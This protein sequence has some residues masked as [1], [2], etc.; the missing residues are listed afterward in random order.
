M[1]RRKFVSYR[2][3]GKTFVKDLSCPSISWIS[4][5]ACWSEI[6]TLLYKN[7]NDVNSLQELAD[8]KFS[9][10]KVYSEAQ[11]VDFDG[12]KILFVDRW[13]NNQ[14]Y[15]HSMGTIDETTAQICMGHLE[16]EWL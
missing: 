10:I 2:I 1:D 13:I 8:G 3:G 14:N 6:M 7:T 16:L 5:Y 4:T 11:E 15:I 9:N 12:R